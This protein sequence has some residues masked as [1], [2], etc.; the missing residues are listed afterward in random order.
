MAFQTGTATDY[1]N[2]LGQ[3]R[4]FALLNGWTSERYDT[5]GANHE[6]ILNGDGDASDQIYVGITT[7]FDTNDGRYNW[8]LSGFTGYT[9]ANTFDAQPGKSPDCY[10]PLMQASMN[11]WFY[12][13]GRRICA[14]IKTGTSFQFLYI[15]FINT[16]ATDLEYPYPLAIIG[17]CHDSDRVF[18]SNAIDYSSVPIPAGNA[19]SG[20]ASGYLRSHDGVWKDLK[21]FRGAGSP[22][23]PDTQTV[24]L[25]PQSYSLAGG[26]T[27]TVDGQFGAGNVF[28]N[29]FASST[30]GG[31]TDRRLMN[32]DNGAAADAVFMLPLILY[33]WDPVVLIGELHN[34]YWVPTFDAQQSEDTVTDGVSADVYTIF[35]NIHRTDPWMQYCVK[36]E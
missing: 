31:A 28:N 36:S 35:N 9:S 2:L 25:W 19:Q 30:A 6:L 23:Y 16:Y 17:S 4:T 26:G 29:I 32:S 22:E 12:V 27:T 24:N 21:N 15:G 11:Y 10:V 33:G 5:S 34:I 14:V 18:N 3:L 8:R 20:S 13:N 7:Y 1:L